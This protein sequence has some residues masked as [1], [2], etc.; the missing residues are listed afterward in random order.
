MEGVRYTDNMDEVL[1][2]ADFLSLHVSLSKSTQKLI[3][4]RELS[5]VKPGSF[6]INTARG[7]ILDCA[8]DA[9]IRKGMVIQ[10]E[11]MRY[12]DCRRRTA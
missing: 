7:E 3:G 5:I 9:T 10:N 8:F 12:K 11:P 1:R 6:L 2:S 4:A